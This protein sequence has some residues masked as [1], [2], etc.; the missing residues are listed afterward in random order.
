MQ[1]ENPQSLSEMFLQDLED[2]EDEIEEETN[3]EKLE[4]IDNLNEE[5]RGSKDVVK[6]DAFKDYESRDLIEQEKKK[7]IES[8]LYIKVTEFLSRM[9]SPDR[10]I[11]NPSEETV[12]EIILECNNLITRIDQQ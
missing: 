11:E 3:L 8:E 12:F 1:T 5:E 9:S 4:N 7:L 10:D 6:A 2:F